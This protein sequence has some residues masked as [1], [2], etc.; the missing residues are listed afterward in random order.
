M[1]QVFIV[2]RSQI[3]FVCFIWFYYLEVF[4]VNSIE[5]GIQNSY[6]TFVVI[7]KK[8]CIWIGVHRILYRYFS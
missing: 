6:F 2:A 8:F 3:Y 1:K 5:G 4:Q 7:D